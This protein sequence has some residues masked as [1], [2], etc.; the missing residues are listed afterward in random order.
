MEN[1][2]DIV[3]E[4][5]PSIQKKTVIKHIWFSPVATYRFLIKE[6]ADKNINILF[7]ASALCGALKRSTGWN[8][9]NL[10]QEWHIMLLIALATVAVAWM[11]YHLY[12]M[13]IQFIA[14][15]LGG[16]GSLLSVQI[17]LAWSLLPY[18]ISTVL[19]LLK[20]AYFGLSVFSDQKVL[21]A[22]RA[23]SLLN[24]INLFELLFWLWSAVILV[25]GVKT[26]H[27]F[28]AFKA[29]VSVIAVPL[30]ASILLGILAFLLFDLV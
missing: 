4:P 6:K 22:E 3:E 16:N 25:I 2:L 23:S 15:L 30:I 28:N 20:I 21:V 27:N 29:A 1:I 14:T 5:G 12:A 17:V 8:V 13:L 18:I 10:S 7:V 11:V 19:I 24:V 9:F 26:A